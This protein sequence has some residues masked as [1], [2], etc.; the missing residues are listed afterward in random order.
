MPA[1]AALT[2]SPAQANWRALAASPMAVVGLWALYAA[3]RLAV[4]AVTGNAPGSPDDWMRLFEV[5]DLLSGQGWYDVAQHRLDPAGGGASMHWSRL[6][7]LPLAAAILLFGTLLPQAQAE[8]AAIAIVP[9]LYL[10]GAMFALRAIMRRLGMAWPA[11]LAG[12]AL[13]PLFPLLPGQ[14][15]PGSVDH[16][17]PQAMLALCCAALLLNAG[18]EAAIVAGVLAAAWVNV[19][20]EGLP[21]VAALGAAYGLAYLFWSERR[22]AWFLGALAI[23]APL[24]SLATRPVSEFALPY[25]D[26]LMPGHMAAF[27]AAALVAM[28][29]HFA[30]AQVRWQGRLAGLGTIAMVSVPVALATLGRCASDPFAQLDPLLATYWHGYITEGLPAWRQ[31]LSVMA[32]LGWTLVIVLAGLRTAWRIPMERQREWLLLGVV[33]SAACL[34]SFLLLRAALVAQLLAVPFAALL[35][36][37][38][39]PRARALASAAPRILATVFCFVLVTPAAASALLK[40]IDP[41]FAQAT[42]QAQV[43]APIAAGSCEYARLEALPQGHV[44]APLDASPEILGRTRHTAVMASYHR[45]QARMRDV[46]AAFT[47]S[48]GKALEIARANGADYVV[49]CLAESDLALYRTAAPGNFSNAIAAGDVAGMSV[50]P[51]FETGPLRVFRLD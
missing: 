4:L 8:N 51:G 38:Y 7:D 2:V 44:L 1:A 31:P 14:F 3:L 15:A 25:C 10:L 46:L 6:V 11:V 13:L 23:S 37:H 50:V 49:A 39:L 19:S 28:A 47:G 27:A 42:M 45:N 41:L 21:L 40:P 35:L 18:R 22:L 17:V 20:L 30:P 26:I 29:L 48:P 32:M 12:L 43:P 16:H 33:A 24:L 34:F 36:A 9:L 5:R